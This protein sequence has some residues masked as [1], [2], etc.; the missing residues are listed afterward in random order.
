[1]QAQLVA[2]IALTVHYAK[3]Q[4]CQDMM[5]LSYFVENCCIVAHCVRYCC[6]LTHIVSI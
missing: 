6:I 1:M 2:V 4:I 5:R 3:L